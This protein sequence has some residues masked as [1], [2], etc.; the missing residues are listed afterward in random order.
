MQIFR[1][2]DDL[3]NLT[4]HFETVTSFVTICLQVLINKII[5]LA[6]ILLS[7]G[8]SDDMKKGVYNKIYV[9]YILKNTVRQ[10]LVPII[11]CI[12]K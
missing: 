4:Y 10:Y 5:G 7:F 11:V 6:S 9:C 8:H 1:K 3:L 12:I 2:T